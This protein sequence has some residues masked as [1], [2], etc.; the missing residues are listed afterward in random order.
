MKIR[1]RLSSLFTLIAAAILLGF[2]F[3]VYYAAGQIRSEE[4]YTV[5]REEGIATAH[6]YFNPK[7]DNHTLRE[8]YRNNKIVTSAVE[9]SLYDSQLRLLYSDAD[10]SGVTPFPI[11]GGRSLKREMHS[12]WGDRQ[13]VTFPYSFGRKHY[14]I[15]ASAYDAYGYNKLRDVRDSIILAFLVSVLLLYL[16]GHFFA[17]QALEPI[18]AMVEKARRISATNLHLRLSEGKPGSRDEL[19][20][21]GVTFNQMLSR[22]ESSFESQKH[23]VSNISHELRTPLAAIISELEL[24]LDREQSQDGYR[25]ALAH[26]LSDARKLVRLSNS[27]LDLAKA[28]YDAS[29][30]RFKEMRVD[31]VLLDAMQ[32]VQQANPAYRID[33]Q[34]EGELDEEHLISVRGNAYLLQVAFMNLMENGCKFSD[35]HKSMLLVEADQRRLRLHFADEGIGIPDVDKLFVPFYRGANHGY[36]EGN[37]IGLSLTRRI[38]ELHKGRLSVRSQIGKGSV[39]TVELIHL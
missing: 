21:L 13:I 25:Q 22:L 7:V 33:L 24:A 31:E 36:A 30:I 27:L 28:S 1:T 32:K 2:A 14:Y 4:F 18:Q 5:L 39:F 37:G 17:R 6:L 19:A 20:E 15:V 8:I 23:F 10:N 9:V 29:E 3:F 34:L 12:Y 26:A 38:I 35:N 16:L 11:H